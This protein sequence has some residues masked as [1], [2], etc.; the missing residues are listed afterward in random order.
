[1]EHMH[2]D[3]TDLEAFFLDAGLPATEV[4]ACPDATCS[5]CTEALPRAA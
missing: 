3:L 4:E 5:F 1:M 2:T